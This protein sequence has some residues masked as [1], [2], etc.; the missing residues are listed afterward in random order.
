MNSMTG[1]NFNPLLCF[2]HKSSGCTI[3]KQ[4]KKNM[5]IG[6][7][8]FKTS[9]QYTKDRLKYIESEIKFLNL[10][11]EKADEL[12]HKYEMKA[13]GIIK[14]IEKSETKKR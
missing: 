7:K 5:C 6:C 3:L 9:E 8:W 2:A 4:Y 12:K 11:S 14:H 10:S 1:K 13:A